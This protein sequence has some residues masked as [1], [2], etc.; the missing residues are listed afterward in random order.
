[1][2]LNEDFHDHEAWAM[3][4]QCSRCNSDMER[5]FLLE[6]GDGSVLSPETWVAGEPQKSVLAGVSLKNKKI[7]EVITFR[8]VA[9]GHLDSYA[10]TQKSQQLL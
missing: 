5:G 1:M 10:L 8:C 6:R 3:S 4:Y 2:L 7:F 9:C